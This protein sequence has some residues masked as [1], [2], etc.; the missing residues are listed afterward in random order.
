MDQL[1]S[2][3]E[4]IIARLGFV[5]S[6]D[7]AVQVPYW[8]EVVEAVESEVPWPAFLER[9]GA[10]SLVQSLV[11]PIPSL[12]QKR[13]GV[14]IASKRRVMD[15]G[16][17]GSRKT[18]SA[19]SALVPIKE[20]YGAADIRTF[21]SCPGYIVPNWLREIERSVPNAS[22]VVITRENRIEAI[23]Q[24]KDP[25]TDFVICSTDMIHRKSAL[26][27]DD[28]VRRRNVRK[29]DLMA[30]YADAESAL[31]RLREL[32][33]PRRYEQYVEAVREGTKNWV[34]VIERIAHEEAK[35]QTDP[36]NEVLSSNVLKDG[37]PLYFILD[38]FHNIVHAGGKTAQSLAHIIR[39]AD[40]RALLSGTGIANKPGDLAYAAYVLGFVDDPSEFRMLVKRDVKKVRAFIDLYALHP[41]NKL[42]DIDPRVPPP[43]FIDFPHELSTQELQ[44]QAA[45]MNSEHF[46]AGE[47]YLLLGYVNINPRKILPSS[48]VQDSGERTLTQKLERFFA[49]NPC[50]VEV[51][52]NCPQSRFDAIARIVSDAPKDRKIAVFSEYTHLVT[53]E[54]AK[55]LQKEGAVVI[56]MT[57]SP[58]PSEIK[59]TP[60][61]LQELVLRG[62]EL[63]HDWSKPLLYRSHLTR[64]MREA[65][66]YRQDEIF[67]LSEREKRLFEFVTNPDKKV[68]VT[69]RGVL[70]EGM[71]VQEIDDI[72]E[73]EPTT[74]PSRRKQT[75]ARAVRSGQRKVIN[76][77]TPFVP[78]SLDTGKID[79]E[80]MKQ[81]SNERLLHDGLIST[82]DLEDHLETRKKPEDFLPIKDFLGLNARAVISLI[83]SRLQGVGAEQFTES[84]AQFNTAYILAEHYNHEWEHGLSAN[85]GRLCKQLI[86]NLEERARNTRGSNFS[87][88]RVL[89]LGCGPVVMNRMLERPTTNIDV[90]RHQM[91]FGLAHIPTGSQGLNY[92]GSVTNL[93]QLVSIDDTDD[94]VFNSRK[95][96]EK[97]AGIG[98]GSYQLAVASCLFY[99]LDRQGIQQCLSEVH[100]SLE[101]GG[102]LLLTM[103]RQKVSDECINPFIADVEQMGFCVDRN[104][105]GTYVSD[106]FDVLDPASTPLKFEVYTLVARKD[107]N[108]APSGDPRFILQPEWQ[109]KVPTPER[110]SRPYEGSKASGILCRG[111]YKKE[112]GLRPEEIGIMGD[113][114]FSDS[115]FDRLRS[116]M[117]GKGI[118][119]LLGGESD[120]SD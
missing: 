48:A 40:W 70:R 60:A 35:A 116:I 33:P 88:E 6:R 73:A 2:R 56:E 22:P 115:F 34:H 81:A 114:P 67:E 108:K 102:Y 65:M 49:D 110:D 38:E 99:F 18:I 16:E 83:F 51:V 1:E 7:F 84:M 39:Q 97:T 44:L 5:P 106:N 82:K 31:V 55:R 50:L 107:P 105:S 24:A 36:I 9:M 57:D 79:Y 119:G 30:D 91:E 98:D 63:G 54:L 37:R 77:Y 62:R 20:K 29:L 93:R 109:I 32:V 13:A 46:E 111:F 19:L 27:G 113:E 80:R 52:K 61:E 3:V 12:P 47:K 101:G 58:S 118:A 72:I 41:I 26:S 75:I 95:A 42:S 87:F 28:F 89:D 112:S 100:R 117:E 78:G 8:K 17:P 45:I 59:L 21:I 15:L 71:N 86:D 4:R 94:C 103:P 90:N 92:L 23:E 43:N 10:D 74:V 66:G 53:G 68:L 25:R 104:V 11:V 64:D 76:V 69:S 14:A 120:G 85:G 96:Y